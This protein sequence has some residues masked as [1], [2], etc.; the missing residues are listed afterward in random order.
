MVCMFNQFCAS[1]DQYC[2]A[3]CKSSTVSSSLMHFKDRLLFNRKILALLLFYVTRKTSTK[4]YVPM[5]SGTSFLLKSALSAT[6]VPNLL[7]PCPSDRSL[8]RE[9][10]RRSQPAG[11]DCNTG[12]LQ[13]HGVNTETARTA[14]GRILW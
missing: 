11:R 1:F 14:P 12:P 8:V 3:L 7:N 2:L 13:G 5:M 10:R 9:R 6:H 4:K